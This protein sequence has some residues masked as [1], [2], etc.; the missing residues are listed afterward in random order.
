[1]TN[2]LLETMPPSRILIKLNAKL[3][4]GEDPYFMCKCHKPAQ[5]ECKECGMRYDGKKSK[6]KIKKETKYEYL[7]YTNF[8][9]T[10]R[11]S[12]NTYQYFNLVCEDCSELVGIQIRREGS[13]NIL[14]GS[15]EDNWHHFPINCRD[16]DCRD[17]CDSCLPNELR[18]EPHMTVTLNTISGITPS[19]VSLCDSE[20]LDEILDAM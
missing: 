11:C 14:V 20:L 3:K 1:M 13:R 17:Y 10:V 12:N 6:K 5:V 7:W 9:S 16:T 8:V 19:N 2:V 15:V 4:Y 18:N